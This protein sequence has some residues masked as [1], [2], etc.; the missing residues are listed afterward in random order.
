MY[1]LRFISS[2]LAGLSS[3]GVYQFLTF[4]DGC[5]EAMAIAVFSGLLAIIVAISSLKI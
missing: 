2:I 4:K 3:V 1:K 5:A